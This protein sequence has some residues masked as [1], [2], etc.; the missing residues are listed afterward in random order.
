MNYQAGNNAEQHQSGTTTGAK[1]F[2]FEWL[3]YNLIA[4]CVLAMLPRIVFICLSTFF[5]SYL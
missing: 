3:T 1:L 4:L 5:K 2:I